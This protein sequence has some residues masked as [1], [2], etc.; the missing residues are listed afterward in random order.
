MNAAKPGK[1]PTRTEKHD[2]A[3]TSAEGKLAGKPKPQKSLGSKIRD[4]L[5]GNS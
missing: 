1:K 5:K 2:K 3:L 4:I